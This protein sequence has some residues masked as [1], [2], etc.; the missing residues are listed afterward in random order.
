MDR[1]DIDGIKYLFCYRSSEDGRWKVC[2]LA[3]L[4]SD[5]G[6]EQVT[7][8]YLSSSWF[9]HA[10]PAQT[11]EFAVVGMKGLIIRRN[12]ETCLNQGS[13]MAGRRRP[14][15]P[16]DALFVGYYILEKDKL[17][18][19]FQLTPPPLPALA[20]PND[21][22]RLSSGLPPIN[23]RISKHFDLQCEPLAMLLGRKPNRRSRLTVCGHIYDE[24]TDGETR[25]S[26][27][28]STPTFSNDARTGTFTYHS[29]VN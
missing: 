22:S 11:C 9:S 23:Q 1:T 8:H 25:R 18:E 27:I 5:K 21:M 28:I 13:P 24:T 4:L 12:M 20:L 15:Y 7:G 3:F 14:N 26:I 16:H 10:F 29:P 17:D 6:P 19:C 2:R